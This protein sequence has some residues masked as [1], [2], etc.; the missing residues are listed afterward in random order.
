MSRVAVP[1]ASVAL[2]A[3]VQFAGA[4]MALGGTHDALITKHAAENGVPEQ[5]VRRVIRIESR[6][7]ADAVHAGNYGLMQIRLGT[8]RA[9]GYSGTAEGLLDPE[10]NLTYAVKYLAGAYR[11]AGCDADRAVSY[12]KRGYYGTKRHDCG[13]AVVDATEIEPDAAKSGLARRK[14]DVISAAAGDVIKPRVVRAELISSSL[15]EPLPMPKLAK[16]EPVRVPPVA[17]RPVP[18]P[19]PKPAALMAKAE[20]ET[21]AFATSG[22]DAVEVVPLPNPKPAVFK[23]KFELAS[24][25]AVAMLG[26]EAAGDVPL[27]RAKPALSQANEPR[28]FRNEHK[29]AADAKH[30]HASKLAER[31]KHQSK[32]ADD[33]TD[34]PGAVISFLKKITST[35]KKPRKQQAEEPMV[36]AQS[37]SQN[38]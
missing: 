38:F 16:F 20:I 33:D 8:A 23:E 26:P 37:P 4:S 3:W 29:N 35:E 18:L 6:G 7:R 15:P 12:Y 5:L 32:K 34:V 25:P 1:I 22:T 36:Q 10:I 14:S 21:T 30:A 27:P 28:G 17:V 19:V 24:A 13:P 9:M 2:A 11:A 31:T